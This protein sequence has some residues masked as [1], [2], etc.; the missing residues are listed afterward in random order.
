MEHNIVVL[1]GYALNPGDLS[2]EPL[3][4]LGRLTVYEHTEED[5]ILERM[6]DATIILTNKTP[7]TEQ[8]IHAC[9]KLQ[10][11]GVMA[12]GYDIIAVDAA[13]EKNI[14][15]TNVPA[16]ST[17]SV[18]QMTFAL[19]LEI[20]H[21]VG[22]HDREVHKGR[23]SANR[24]F[25]FWD[26]PGIE[27][28]GKTIGIV[29]YGQIGSQVSDLALALGMDVLAYRRNP[30][31]EK[32]HDH[33]HFVSLE[34]LYRDSDIISFHVPANKDTIKMV[35]D[36]S[37]NMMKDNVILINTARGTLFDET[38][39]AAHLETGKIFAV[40]I[41]VLSKEPPLTTNPLLSA[42]RCVITPHIAWGTTE[43]RVRC[44][45]IAGSNVASFI[46]G[47]ATHT[48]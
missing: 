35:N 41:D 39:V 40:G 32:E 22:H 37:I 20:C 5:R 3:E 47:D 18:A 10:Y 44:M 16:Y 17:Y 36:E 2:W 13:H 15:V 7:I 43:A 42:P 30:D 26:V 19:L 38:A 24:D 12:T 29:G 31:P 1:D 21:H 25:C 8:T 45:D 34:T 23:W 14:V 48:I 6:V 11:I 33:L 4:H 28:Q 9:K 46:R 27:L